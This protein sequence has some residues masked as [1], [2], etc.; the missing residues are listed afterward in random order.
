VRLPGRIAAAIEVL[1]DIEAR[2]RPASEAL[3]E[4]GLAHRFA[5]SG[6]R[7][8]I[9][10]LVYDALR[11]RAS[12]AWRMEGDTPWHLALGAAL[13]E[14]GLDPAAL[15][16]SFATDPHAPPPV[17]DELL[18][19]LATRSLAAAPDPVRADVPEWIA[20]HFAAAF[21]ASW[22]EEGRALADRPPLDLRVN[23]LKADRDKV[24]RQLARFRVEPTP[25]SPLGLRIA[26]S[27]GQGRHPNVQAEEAFLRGRVEVQDEGSQVCALLV[28]ARPGE[29][30]LDFCAGAGGKTLALAAR[31]ENRG[32]IYAYDSDRSRLAPIYDRVKRAGARNVQIRSPASGALDDLRGQMDRVLVD[33]PCTGT[34]IWRRRPDA[35]WRVTEDAL[36]KRVAE[37]DIVLNQ[38]AQFVRPGGVLAY[39]TCSLLPA[40][41]GGRI[42]AFRATHA[43]FELLSVNEAWRD[44]LSDAM[45]PAAAG[46]EDTL[47]LSPLRTGTDGF[48]LA[49]MRR[50]E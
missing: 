34:G 28:G 45:P 43:D 15:N 30:V 32:Q 33:A 46:A 13:F 6:D 9:G 41:N 49:L 37:Q 10:N 22:V 3:K 50:A 11:R 31:M 39:A 29:Q 38:A 40:E 47:L 14:W 25:F 23:S 18:A 7:A 16:G 5:G 12:I 4:W 36:S 42:A 20:P 24:A 2:H 48:F 26:P 44:A 27:V 1:A 19:Q 35:K 8:A 17:P 21:G